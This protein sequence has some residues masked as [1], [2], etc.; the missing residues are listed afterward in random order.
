MAVLGAL[1]D[2]VKNYHLGPNG[3]LTEDR[4]LAAVDCFAAVAKTW[5]ELAISA[6]APLYASVPDASVLT[7]APMEFTNQVLEVHRNLMAAYTLA[8]ALGAQGLGYGV[9]ERHS[10]EPKACRGIPGRAE[11]APT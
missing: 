4:W 6:G 9:S 7:K 8:L 10:H 11:D 1:V 3:K 5:L 2:R